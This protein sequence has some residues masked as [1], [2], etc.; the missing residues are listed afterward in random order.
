MSQSTDTCWRRQCLAELT[1]WGQDKMAAVLQA[2]FSNTFVWMKINFDK[3]F[4]EF[5]YKS[6]RQYSNIGSSN[7]LAP[8]RRQAIILTNA[9]LV[10]WRIYASPRL[11]MVSM[12][13]GVISYAAY[14]SCGGVINKKI[15]AASQKKL[16]LIAGPE[17]SL[18]VGKRKS[19]VSVTRWK[20]SLTYIAN[21]EELED[22][23]K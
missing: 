11:N 7:V 17:V 10:Y 8:N 23:W 19:S 15:F 22:L 21:Q 6:N 2:T 16:A 14:F 12:G 9:D 3:N 18:V 13:G 20:M 4:T 1:H 5:S